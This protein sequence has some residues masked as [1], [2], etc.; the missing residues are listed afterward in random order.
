MSLMGD[1]PE[2]I[3]VEV[4]V[5]EIKSIIF[6]GT[7]IHICNCTLRHI[8]TNC[9]G[10]LKG[11]SERINGWLVRKFSANDYKIRMSTDRSHN[12]LESRLISTR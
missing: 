3:N 4:P 12:I 1:F 9:R 5:L 11:V 2:I 7:P 10:I 8:N 6:S